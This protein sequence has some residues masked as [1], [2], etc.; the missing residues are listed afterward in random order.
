MSENACR[1]LNLDLYYPHRFVSVDEVK[2]QTG[3]AFFSKL[4][5]DLE[6]RLESK[7]YIR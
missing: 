6:E 1:S 3:L 4:P 5:D 2:K 7:L